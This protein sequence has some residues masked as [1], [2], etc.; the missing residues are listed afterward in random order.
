[1][2]YKTKCRI[3]SDRMIIFTSVLIRSNQETFVTTFRYPPG[4]WHLIV[5]RWRANWEFATQWDNP[6]WNLEKVFV[7]Y[8]VFFKGFYD[9]IVVYI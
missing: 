6:I 4:A 7:L 2:S 3:V 5:R 1:M 9:V 8:G